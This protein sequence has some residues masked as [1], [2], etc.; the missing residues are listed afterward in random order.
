MSVL[1]DLTPESIKF[2]AEAEHQDFAQRMA[3]WHTLYES[4]H[5]DVFT[6]YYRRWG[7]PE[8]LPAALER[9]RDSAPLIQAALPVI[10]Q[11]VADV[12]PQLC[13]LLDVAEWLP[14]FVL[15]VGLFA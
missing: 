11:G 4:P 12:P 7:K 10:R 9:F 5:R 15:L 1:A 13:S 2:W 8:L 3:L 14:P 6:L